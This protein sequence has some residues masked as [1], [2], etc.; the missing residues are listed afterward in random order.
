[1]RNS[2]TGRLV[3]LITVILCLVLIGCAMSLHYV[4][5]LKEHS[6]YINI[7]S[8]Q[9]GRSLVISHYYHSYLETDVPQ[10]Y[11]RYRLKE[12]IRTYQ[13]TFN[14]LEESSGHLSSHDEISSILEQARTNWKV[15]LYP[16]VV[17]YDSGNA[18]AAYMRYSNNVPSQE[19][20]LDRIV[21][22]I[23]QDVKND[24]KEFERFL[25]LIFSIFIFVMIWAFR[26]YKNNIRG[27]LIS[28]ATAANRI[29]SGDY[30]AQV[31]IQNT[32]ELSEIADAFNMMAANINNKTR[33]LMLL[34]DFSISLSRS[35]TLEQ[36]IELMLQYVAVLVGMNAAAVGIFSEE[37]K[38]IEKLSALGLP[39]DFRKYLES[40]LSS[41]P[42]AVV[43]L[44]EPVITTLTSETPFRMT[45][46][47]IDLNIRTMLHIPLHSRNKVIGIMIL[48]RKYNAEFTKEEIEILTTFSRLSSVA[49]ENYR[50][51]NKILLLANTDP[52]TGL[53]NRRTLEQQLENEARRTDRTNTPFTLIMIDVDYFKRINDEYGHTSGDLVLMMIANYFKKEIRGMDSLARY[54]GEEFS[55][56]LPG[57]DS[58]SGKLTADRIRESLM[59]MK[60]SLADN[61]INI[62]ISI[63]IAC[64][65]EDTDNIN[66][67][68]DHADKAL[69]AAKNAGR[70]C[71][72][73]YN[74]S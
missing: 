33:R 20:L 50:L 5:S 29:S 54:G 38:A 27:P 32:T 10:P 4:F 72:K 63:G 8:K 57:M 35:S 19:L 9:R 23:K 24:L 59:K 61:V 13:D 68:V 28:L 21:S 14:M 58:Q 34:N 45:E 3:L 37:F 56:I 44:I 60:F 43:E 16:Y 53:Y 51:K 39:D 46:H 71:V 42:G 18:M 30:G 48:Y 41:K 62:T 49:I 2:I 17:Q 6:E 73:T 47:E 74:E 55:I 67:L 66:D 40:E 11:R 36:I 52:L 69:Y 25:I 1:M 22:L 12:E 31:D 65:K 70:N 7:A 26:Y 64:Y 15:N